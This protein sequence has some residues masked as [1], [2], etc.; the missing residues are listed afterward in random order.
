M[1]SI[2]FFLWFENGFEFYWLCGFRCEINLNI[3]WFY[4]DYSF[5]LINNNIFTITI[6]GLVFIF[7][8][9]AAYLNVLIVSLAFDF[10]GD[11]H[12]ICLD[13]D[14]IIYY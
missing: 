11:M 1:V 2:Y 10:A 5:L 7:F 14:K 9:R 6:T 12:A 8:A 13:K 3:F 4:F